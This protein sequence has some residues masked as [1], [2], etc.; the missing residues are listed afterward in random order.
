MMHK[1]LIAAVTASLLCAALSVAPAAAQAPQINYNLPSAETIQKQKDSRRNIAV[2]ERVGR[3]IMGAFELYSEQNDVKGAIAKLEEASPRE[4][5]DIAYV[6]RF[7]GNLYAADEQFEKALS[8]VKKAA[9]A[10]VLGWTDQA[11]ALKL[12]ADLSLQLERYDQA[13]RKS[14]V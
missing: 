10:D 5:F 11:G 7:L 14:V 3:N 8:L 13:D 6:S 4:A 2:S 1:K 12:T 9:D